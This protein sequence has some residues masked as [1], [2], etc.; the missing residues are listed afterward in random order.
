MFYWH[1][2]LSEPFRRPLSSGPG[3][4][5]FDVAI[6]VNRRL[7]GEEVALPHPLHSPSEGDQWFSVNDIWDQ[8]ELVGRSLSD[9]IEVGDVVGCGREGQLTT[10]YTRVERGRPTYLTS[11]KLRGVTTVR[12][13]DIKNVIGVYRR[14]AK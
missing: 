4:N 5:C 9:A 11:H 3:M 7:H 8:W 6:E 10:V 13:A 1:D 2:L 14:R 12:P